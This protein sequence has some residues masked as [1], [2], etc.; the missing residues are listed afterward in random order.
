[1]LWTRA[2]DG[3]R[4]LRT[5]WKRWR[6]FRAYFQVAKIRTGCLT[7]VPYMTALEQM[8]DDGLLELEDGEVTWHWPDDVYSRAPGTE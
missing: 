3:V 7:F 8:Q 1:M 2:R 4:R 6:L 5:R